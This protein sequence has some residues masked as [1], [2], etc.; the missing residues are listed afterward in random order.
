MNKT[1]LI[2][3]I[4]V[5]FVAG[6]G[7]A[8]AGM[9]PTI[10]LAGTVNLDGNQAK[11]VGTPT[12]S[13]DATTKAYVDSGITTNAGDVAALQARVDALESL[14][15]SMSAVGTD[16]FFEGVNVHIRDGTGS[17]LCVGPCNGVGNLIVGYDE[18]RL[19]ASDKTGAHN[20]VV[21]PNHNYP[22]Y[23]GLVAGLE[24]TVSGTFSSV[25]GGA[26]N[27]AS[28]TESSI[29][30][31]V[32]NGAIGDRSSVSG[33]DENRASG[34]RSSISGGIENRASGTTSS[35]SGGSEN[36]ASERSSSVSGGSDNNANGEF[37]SV[38]GGSGHTA[39]GRFDWRAGS[40]F[41]D[42]DFEIPDFIKQPLYAFFNL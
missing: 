28:G 36:T 16:L 29:S 10:T 6:I 3:I 19:A 4:A 27:I 7:T 24:N 11:N 39:S 38:S 5:T 33:G 8:Y 2:G 35:V 26:F 25:S 17:T 22:T 21:G 34:D 18:A 41:Q 31:G 20:L 9:N 32:F 13:N 30:G 23:G 42:M 40:L 1:I 37:S 14:T 15:T 12:D